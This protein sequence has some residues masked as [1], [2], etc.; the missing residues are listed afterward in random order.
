MSFKTAVFTGLGT[1]ILMYGVVE[2]VGHN[3]Y[4]WTLQLYGYVIL[5]AVVALQASETG[6]GNLLGGFSDRLL[7]VVDRDERIVKKV[8]KGEE[9]KITGTKKVQ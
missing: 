4:T 5:A 6:S 8:L 7:Y 2:A 3:Y 1:A 9:F